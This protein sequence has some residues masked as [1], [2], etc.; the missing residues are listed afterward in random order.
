MVDEAD[1]FCAAE[2]GDAA[3][4]ARGVVPWGDVGEGVAID[5][6]EVLHLKARDGIDGI[7]DIVV[8]L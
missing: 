1:G 3:N 2:Y 6:A 4:D 8:R 7:H 5:D